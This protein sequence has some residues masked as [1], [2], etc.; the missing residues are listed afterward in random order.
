M[1]KV[2]I[3]G[4]S[5]ILGEKLVNHFSSCFEVVGTYCNKPKNNFLHLDLTDALEVRKFFKHEKPDLVLLV[6]A[7]TDVAACEKNLGLAQR[8]N[9]FGV[10]NVLDQ[11][12]S[13]IVFF[14]TD[15]V[16]DGEK[17]EYF[18]GDTPN[19]LNVYGKTK[20]DAENLI[21][22]CPNYLTI[23]T[24]RLYSQNG[25]KF[26]NKII[27]NLREGEKVIVPRDTQGSVSFADDVAFATLELVNRNRDGTY[28]VVGDAH[29]F[30]EIAYKLS[31]MFGFNRDLIV[32]VGKDY[33][34]KDIKRANVVLNTNK[35][36]NEGIRIRNL[37]EGLKTYKLI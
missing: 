36:N 17:K 12:P 2:A 31:D 23:R 32:V 1:Q 11:K 5:G 21:K 34:N 24:S 15:A 14:S 16:F 13:K 27:N 37:E 6:S 26:L 20:L 30:D 28:H 10:K 35:L 25:V 33:F 22:I 4:A 18:E 8:I 7:M 19:P 3:I 29:S 9:F